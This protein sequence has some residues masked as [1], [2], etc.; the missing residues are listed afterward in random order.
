MEKNQNRRSFIST[1]VTST[2]TLIA[3][4]LPTKQFQRNEGGNLKPVDIFPEYEKRLDRILLTVNFLVTEDMT[5]HYADFLTHLPRYTHLELS[6]AEDATERFN[7]LLKEWR[8][9][10]SA[11][12]YTIPATD[13][14][15][16]EL[17]SSWIQDIA[18]AVRSNGHEAFLVSKKI[19]PSIALQLRGTR[20]EG[21]RNRQR[22]IYQGSLGREIIEAP[23]VFEGG[24]IAF[25]RIGRH[26]IAFVGYNDIL[27]TREQYRFEGKDLSHGDILTLI[28]NQFSG[29]RIVVMGEEPQNSR[30]FHL[31]Q[32][33][34]LLKNRQAIV[35]SVP[36]KSSSDAR[37][38]DRYAGRLRELG[39][40]VYRL[41]TTPFDIENSYA[42]LN[43]LPFMHRETGR[44]SMVYPVFPGEAQHTEYPLRHQLTADDLRGKGLVMYRLLQMAGYHPIP[45]QDRNYRFKGGMHCLSI[46]LASRSLLSLETIG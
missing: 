7:T 4:C 13:A 3:G 14:E 29:A 1:L 8:V 19:A 10:N 44:P 35:V 21:M 2:A 33:M 17:F 27:A 18:K 31:D 36:D 11:T 37:R 42:T 28:R 43:G 12:S 15:T 41:P 32:S 25:D 9:P 40:T 39:Y 46:I 30:F 22:Q 45:V 20:K 24:N 6:I 16:L 38:H 26:P 34:L 23:F 5:T